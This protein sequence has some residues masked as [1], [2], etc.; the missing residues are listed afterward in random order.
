MQLNVLVAK[1][2]NGQNIQVAPACL[3]AVLGYK[4]SPT[5][6]QYNDCLGSM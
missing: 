5:V 6:D 1:L 3:C 4:W 2:S